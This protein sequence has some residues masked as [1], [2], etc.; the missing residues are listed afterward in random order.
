MGSSCSIIGKC[1]DR[2]T[3]QY[4][5]KLSKLHRDLLDIK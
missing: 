1:R 5:N 4:T 3:K 2:K